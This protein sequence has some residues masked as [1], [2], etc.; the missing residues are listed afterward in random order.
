MDYVSD[1]QNY[2]DATLNY[3]LYFQLRDVYANGHSFKEIETVLT[4]INTHFK[5]PK[6]L[7]VFISNHDNPRFLS[8]NGNHIRLQGAVAFTL[9]TSN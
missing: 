4:Q 7:G 2:I 8:F 1:Y 3:P 9:F 5:D 6:A